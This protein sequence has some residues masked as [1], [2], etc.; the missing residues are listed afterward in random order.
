MRWDIFLVDVRVIS[1]NRRLRLITLTETLISNCNRTEWSPVRSVIAQRESDLFITSMIFDRIGRHEVLL[2]ITHKNYN[3]CEKKNSQ[4]IK[5][6][7][8]LH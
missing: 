1:R 3:F 4:V 2:P 6:R 8:N 7:E 5:E